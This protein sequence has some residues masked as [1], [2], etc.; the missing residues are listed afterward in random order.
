MGKTRQVLLKIYHLAHFCIKTVGGLLKNR[1]PPELLP[2]KRWRSAKIMQ[3]TSTFVLKTLLVCQIIADRQHLGIVT[4]VVYP[5]KED[6]YWLADRL[7][8]GTRM[9]RGWWL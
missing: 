6:F 9:R 3:T 2:R 5:A 8:V 1:R 7:A 4:V